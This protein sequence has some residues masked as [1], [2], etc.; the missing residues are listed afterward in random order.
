MGS[1]VKKWRMSIDSQ[2]IYPRPP[3]LPGWW[4]FCSLHM[5]IC[6]HGREI[7]TSRQNGREIT[8]SIQIPTKTST[9][10]QSLSV[11]LSLRHKTQTLKTKPKHEPKQNLNTTRDFVCGPQPEEHKHTKKKN[12]Q[13]YPKKNSTLVKTLSAIRSLRHINTFQTKP[14]TKPNKPSSRDFVCSAQSETHK[15]IPT[16]RHKNPNPPPNKPRSRLFRFVVGGLF[17]V[18]SCVSD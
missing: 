4:G 18:C 2:D 8:T 13:K 6:V 15:H 12:P 14:K 16:W 9:W 7:T 5:C 3:R 17:L 1:K 10:F 11:V